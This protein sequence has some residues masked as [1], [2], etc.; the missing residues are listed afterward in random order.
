[1]LISYTRAINKEVFPEAYST[2]RLKPNAL[3]NRKKF[4][5]TSKKKW[6]FS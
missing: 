4:G 2:L 1:M 6:E 3:Q 5:E